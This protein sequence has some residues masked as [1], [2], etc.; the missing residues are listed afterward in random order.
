[1]IIDQAIRYLILG[2]VI[3]IPLVFGA[4]HPIILGLY[5]FILLVGCGGWLLLTVNRPKNVSPT[6]WIAVP[7]L[8]IGYI[9]FQ[10]IPIPLPVVEF[11][12]PGRAVRITM[13]NELAGTNINWTTLSDNGITGFYRSFFFFGLLLYYF[14]LSRILSTDRQFLSILI[15]CL[16]A[17]GTFEALYGILQFLKPQ[18]GLLWLSIKFRAAYGT[19]IYKNQ[20]ASM[21][22]MLWPIAIT[23]GVL[24]H[25]RK[26]RR[27]RSRIENNKKENTI[28]SFTITK[29]QAPIFLFGATA[30]ILAVIFSLSRG[31][32]LSML[33]VG[34]LL[35]VMLPFSRK[36]KLLFLGGFCTVIVS[37]VAMIG[38]DT[39]IDRFSALG[40]S[41]FGRLDI[42][43]GS[44]P[45]LVENWITGVGLGSYNLLSPIYL[46]GFPHNIHFDRAHSEYLEFMIELGIP[47]GMLFLG[48]IIVGMVILFYRL[49][50][51]MKN[52][53]TN[54][55]M[56]T[57]GVATFC[58][59]IGFL[60]H[61]IIDFGWRLPAN[62]IYAVT[63][64]AIFR[65]CLKSEEIKQ[66]QSQE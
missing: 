36:S 39:I 51:I 27:I 65:Y 25:T 7:L 2:I 32:I 44:I 33:L 61:G 9:I 34:L 20:Y 42:Y 62:L 63:L 19:I 48:W 52:A 57:I 23:G 10:S 28:E 40:S 55:D 15:V 3:T 66:N 56:T 11:L 60:M 16:V 54:S 47:F 49:F 4:V 50:V 26:K 30:M 58:G 21:L 14:T 12:S 22:N 17:V 35:I 24:Y 8:L 1:M 64:L 18:L 29:L 31:G 37:Y 41:G 5:V 43:L 59:L 13:V 38:I 46:K 45:M 53:R 6:F